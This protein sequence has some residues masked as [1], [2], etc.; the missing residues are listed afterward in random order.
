MQRDNNRNMRVDN[1]DEDEEA[2]SCTGCSFP[3]PPKSDK[4]VISE[5]IHSGRTPGVASRRHGPAK[6]DIEIA[7][8][9]G[10]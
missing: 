3:S 10:I 9:Q 4:A 6:Q 8:K 2:G 1:V 5:R 7:R